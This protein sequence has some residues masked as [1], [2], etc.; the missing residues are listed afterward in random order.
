MQAGA[1]VVIDLLVVGGGLSGGLLAYRVAKRRPHLD[2]RLVERE[3]HSGGNHT[4]SFHATDL[5]AEQRDWIAPFVVRS[6]QDHEVAFPALRRRLQA[7]YHSIT[8]SRF[9]EVIAGALGGRFKPQT[10]VTSVEPNAVTFENGRRWSARAVVDARGTAPVPGWVLGYQKFL[11]RRVR[12]ARPHGVAA[13]VL[14]DATVPQ[15]DGYR[16]FYLL[17]WSENEL[18]IEDT[19][20]SD[21]PALDRDAL[22]SEIQTYAEGHGW[23][24]GEVVAE[25]EG[26]L[27]IPIRGSVE[28]LL[29]QTPEGVAPAGTRAGLFHATTG[30]SLPDAVRT[31]DAL[32]DAW[33]MDGPGLAQW[34]RRRAR[35]HW[36]NQKF[37]RLLNGLLFRA[38]APDQRFRVLERFYGLSE[39][40]I[41]RFY[42]GAL[43]Y[44]DRVR[45]L[46]GKPPVPLRAAA[47]VLFGTA[48]GRS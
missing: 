36:R 19:R 22:R 6:W 40:L 39:A 26:I 20:Y 24:G 7:A 18:L 14:M 29:E 38:A 25:E 9:H 48:E 28:A 17:P 12:F 8:S 32:V 21:T 16:F 33:P 45:M 43:T 35:R 41:A 34:M 11:G 15:H 1:G 42:A 2:V 10:V 47:R 27:P 46:A 13:P 37:A 5:T 44:G 4:W 31:A 3:P 30:Y 23:G